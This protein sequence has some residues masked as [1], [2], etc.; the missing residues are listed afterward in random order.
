LTSSVIK[1][2]AKL[3]WSLRVG[4]RRDDGYHDLD[5]EM[6][7]IDLCDTLIVTEPGEG[8]EFTASASARAQG[9]GVEADNLILRAL[10]VAGRRAHVSLTKE[11]PV[12]GGLGGGSS[13]AAAILRWAGVSDLGVAASLGG[14][15][16]F[17][18][19]GGRARV[20]GLGEVVEPLDDV[21]R[22][23][24]L[25]V[26]P[27]GVDTAAAYRAL[28]E[29]RHEGGGHHERNDLTQAAERVAPGLLRWRAAFAEATGAEPVLTGSGSTLFVEGSAASCG[30]GGLDQLV[31]D[32][33]R[34]TLL[35]ARTISAA[36][37]APR[38]Y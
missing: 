36:A 24:L 20:R 26:P 6:V 9:L 7:S 34:G 31:V 4:E 27:F 8:L 1:A 35:E 15:V 23:V 29:L 12:G 32:G 14:D 28:D 11:I 37:G 25:L 30:L 10:D 22:S 5:S 16:P 18:L 2:P 33:E 13:D 21:D 17:C 19:L 3:T 38:E